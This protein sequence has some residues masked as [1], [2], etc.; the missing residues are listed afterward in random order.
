VEDRNDLLITIRRGLGALAAANVRFV[1]VGEVA[2][3]LHGLYRVTRRV[4][5]LVDPDE[6][7]A[8]AAALRRG[9]RLRTEAPSRDG[10]QW[11][12]NDSVGCH[13]AVRA[14]VAE[15][16]RTVF[17]EGRPMRIFG[18]HGH[19]ATLAHLLVLLQIHHDPYDTWE[20]G[21]FEMI[22]RSRRVDLDAA[23]R[24]LASVNRDLV[25][26]WQERVAAAQ[27]P[28][29]QRKNRFERGL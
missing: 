19:V 27:R 7:E 6:A 24:L 25:P 23:E 20:Q 17:A 2:M 12:A 8:A 26:A 3:A 10:K 18:M 5:I 11:F 4:D 1:V 13:V 9:A 15:P 16:E 22:V 21:D 29:R 14:A 28:R